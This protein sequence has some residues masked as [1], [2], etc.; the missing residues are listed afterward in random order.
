MCQN[1][2]KN[3]SFDVSF[4]HELMNN[5]NRDAMSCK[6]YSPLMYTKN[7]LV[8]FCTHLQYFDCFHIKL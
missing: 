6:L 4:R 8:V 5:S 7:F 1:I 2:S 3:A